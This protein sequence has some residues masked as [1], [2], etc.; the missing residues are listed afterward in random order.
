M[1]LPRRQ[2]AAMA[3]CLT[4]YTPQQIRVAYGIQPLLG[5][6]VTGRGQTVVLLEF[7][8]EAAGSSTTVTGALQVPAVTDIRQD[9]ARFDAKFSLPAAS[10]LGRGHRPGGPVRRPGSR[11]RQSRL[12]PDRPQHLLP[13]GVPRHHDREQH[14]AEHRRLPGRARVGSGDRLGQP[15]RASAGPA[16]RPPMTQCQSARCGRLP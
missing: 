2:G 13:P 5:H 14:R 7:P 10:L 12:V 16:A 15:G 3:D 9:L 11:L 1:A 4:C 8:P 6:G